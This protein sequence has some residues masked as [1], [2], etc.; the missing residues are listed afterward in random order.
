[1]MLLARDRGPYTVMF[2]VQGVWGGSIA[3]WVAMS[4]RERY[5]EVQCIM[6]NR[7]METEWQTQVKTLPANNFIGGQ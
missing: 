5:S 1:M 6:C 3:Q 7:Q 4:R 2:R